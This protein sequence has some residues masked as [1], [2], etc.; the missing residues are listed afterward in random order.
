MLKRS[1]WNWRGSVSQVRGSHASSPKLWVV[2]GLTGLHQG[3]GN[4]KAQGAQARSKE[5]QNKV[6]KDG[7]P[8]RV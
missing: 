4:P 6:R 1:F 5:R 2:R 8:H 7:E 3:L